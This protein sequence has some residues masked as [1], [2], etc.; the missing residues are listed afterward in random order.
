MSYVELDQT[1]S[2]SL[3]LG[4]GAISSGSQ[5][6]LLPTCSPA[7]SRSACIDDLPS[8]SSYP[9]TAPFYLL[10]LLLPVG[11]EGSVLCGGPDGAG[12]GMFSQMGL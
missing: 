7:V 12:W 2:R 11:S 9:Q 1:L 3:R 8:A 4:N 5:T 6:P 10:A